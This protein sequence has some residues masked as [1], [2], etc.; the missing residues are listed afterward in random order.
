M[1][2]GNPRQAPTEV[3]ANEKGVISADP[4]GGGRRKN[5]AAVDVL[6]EVA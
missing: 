2:I 4:L 1:A 3:G 6:A 5:S